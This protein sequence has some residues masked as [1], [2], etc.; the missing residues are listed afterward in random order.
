MNEKKPGLSTEPKRTSMLIKYTV[1]L[2]YRWLRLKD[3]NVTYN[4]YI[5]HVQY[6]DLSRKK[7]NQI[8]KDAPVL[9]GIEIGR[10]N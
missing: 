9:H 6:L 7:K 2:D 8:G 5:F 1:D 3:Q 4:I 10:K